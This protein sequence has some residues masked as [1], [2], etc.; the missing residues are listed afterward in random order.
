MHYIQN[1]SILPQQ[2]PLRAFF[3]SFQIDFYTTLRVHPFNRLAFYRPA[4]SLF[5]PLYG[6]PLTTK[7]NI[8]KLRPTM[9]D[10]LNFF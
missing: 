3:R 7:L 6:K 1:V 9:D 8:L 5:I 2:K 4:S 10:V